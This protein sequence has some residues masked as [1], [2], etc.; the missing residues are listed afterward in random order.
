MLYI[1]QGC[2][3]EKYD[4]E[5]YTLYKVVHRRSMRMLYI[6]QGCIKEKYDNVIHYTRLYIGEV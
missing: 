2:I 1:I 3:Y 6:I 4:R 5:C